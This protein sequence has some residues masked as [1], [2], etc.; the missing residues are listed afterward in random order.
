VTLT[1]L[2]TKAHT[3]TAAYSG[4]INY[5]AVSASENITI[6]A[7]K[8]APA[9]VRLSARANPATSTAPVAF[10]IEVASSGAKPTGEVELH[11]GVVVLARAALIR[12][13]ASLSISKLDPGSHVLT[14]VYSGDSEHEPATSTPLKEVVK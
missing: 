8:K 12:A 5:A 14:A 4:D 6:T 10:S 3:L 7:V 1:G 9:V 13:S 2:S 11:E